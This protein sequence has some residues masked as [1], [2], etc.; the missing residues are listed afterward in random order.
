MA[1]VNDNESKSRVF[2]INDCGRKL[3]ILEVMINGVEHTV[4]CDTV[5]FE[6]RRVIGGKWM[7]F[8]GLSNCISIEITERSATSSAHFTHGNS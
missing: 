6:S 3:Y 8:M 4:E 7:H 5:S 1:G 2:N